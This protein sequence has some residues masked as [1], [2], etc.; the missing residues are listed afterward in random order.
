MRRHPV[1]IA[2]YFVKTV[3]FVLLLLFML[4][5]NVQ[6]DLWK[7]HKASPG[8]PISIPLFYVATGVDAVIFIGNSFAALIDYALLKDMAPPKK[9]RLSTIELQLEKGSLKKLV[10]DLPASAKKQYY[11]ARLKYPD[12]RWRRI[13]YRLR[14]RSPWHWLPE[15]PSLRLKL[16]KSHPISLQRHINLINPEDR[17]MI[18]NPFGDELARKIGVL[19][20][21][22][23]IVR[24]FIN[25][26]YFGVY[27]MTTREDESML[28]LNRRMPGPLFR[29]NLV[30]PRWRAKQF[31]TAGETEI[32]KSI[33]PL[34]NMV[35]AMYLPLGPERFERLWRH[36]DRDKMA[37]WLTAMNIAGSIHTDYYHNHLYYFD[38]T[39]GLIEPGVED[40]MGHG[41][42]TY[43]DRGERLTQ[44]WRPKFRIPLNERMSPMLDAVLRDPRFLHRRNQ[45]LY[46]ALAGVASIK[47]QHRRLDRMF[48]DMDPDVRTDLHKGAL[49]F[50]PADWFRFPYSN[51]QYDE[52]KRHL[53]AWIENRNAFIAR[54]LTQTSVRVTVA[55][56]GASSRTR[57]LIEVN[58]NAAVSFDSGALKGAVNGDTRFDGTFARVLTAPEL[59]YPGLSESPDGDD[60]TEGDRFPEHFL[61]PDQQR[62]LLEVDGDQLPALKRAF[63]HALT[64]KPIEP[65]IDYVDTID[66]KAVKYNEVSVHI[67]RF[68]AEPE[69]DV[70][71]GPGVVELNETL[72]VAPKQRLVVRPGTRLRLGKGVSIASR[73]RVSM[74]GTA[75]Q[76]IVVERLNPDEPWGVIAIQGSKAEGSRIAHARIQ[77]GSRATLFNI[78]YSGMVSVHWAGGFRMEDS[79]LANNVEGDDTL[80]V[81]H[82]Q[83][84]LKRVKVSDCFGDC[85]DFDYT[86][87]TIDKVRIARAGND[88]LDFMTSKVTITDTAIDG[89][90]DKGVS[91][92]EA[93][94]LTLRR[95]TV[96]RAKLGVAVKDKS[97][98]TFDNGLIK[99]NAI[100]VDI[101]AKNWRYGGPGRAVLKGTRLVNNKTDI[102]IAKNGLAELRDSGQKL[103]IA[104][105]GQFRHVN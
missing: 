82:S 70:V 12:G 27:H 93:S 47:N 74:V 57:L 100:G 99:D 87:G 83:A 36:L 8:E 65:E 7:R 86:D 4:A 77:G 92:G 90:G 26:R 37:R 28:R 104:G 101:Y 49:Q 84:A 53:Y 75:A 44:A 41:A 97:V 42:I 85:V 10:S 52:S 24:V 50:S 14:G 78:R 39:T 63:Q 17:P 64:G 23:Q 32:L 68:P 88:G 76:P 30:G 80:R 11:R 45:L 25:G 6:Y 3:L 72:N 59:L 34:E 5:G 62:Y 20:H 95:M 33:Q 18:A 96:R 73:G 2:N 71:L 55:Q 67:W 54:K 31:E 46:S 19:T 29:G 105:N 66:P 43:P 51:S 40:I 22:N 35:E 61:A 79:M 48:T 58:G 91:A 60:P 89:A 98:V 15:K 103:N 94:E 81:V 1:T 56:N 9:S 38:P 69:G 13:K 21:R 102:R 16:K